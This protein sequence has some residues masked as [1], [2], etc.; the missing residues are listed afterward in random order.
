MR[1]VEVDPVTEEEIMGTLLEIGETTGLLAEE[2]AL[3]VF[4][5]EVAAAG[6]IAWMAEQIWA[7]YGDAI[8][9]FATK[10][11]KAQWNRVR[12][13]VTSSG[14]PRKTPQ[15]NRG[16]EKRKQKRIEFK[17][18]KP[19]RN[20]ASTPER[21][22]EQ[23]VDEAEN[24]PPPDSQTI[25]PQM[26]KWT[27]YPT[28]SMCVD[29]G[30]MEL[31]PKGGRY[32]DK[33]Y[34]DDVVGQW[35]THRQMYQWQ[36]T[37][38]SDAKLFQFLTESEVD[39]TSTTEANGSTSL[40]LDTQ[41]TEQRHQIRTSFTKTANY[42][43]ASFNS[44]IKLNEI[45]EHMP[46]DGG[47][48]TQT[49]IHPVPEGGTY[50]DRWAQTNDAPMILCLKNQ[51]IEMHIK[52]MT[53]AV[54][55]PADYNTLGSETATTPSPLKMTLRVLEALNDILVPVSASGV[56]TNIFNETMNEGFTRSWDI[57]RSDTPYNSDPSV[58]AQSEQNYMV[59]YS[60]NQYLTENWKVVDK[61]EFCLCPGQEGTLKIGLPKKQVLSMQYLLNATKGTIVSG[62][63]G[64]NAIWRMKTPFI[65]KGEQHL[66][67][68]FHGGLGV[69]KVT[70]NATLSSNISPVQVA[71]LWTHSYE[72]AVLH[73]ANKTYTIKTIVDKTKYTDYSADVD[74]N[75]LE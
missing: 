15:K 45:L 69:A 68:E 13:Y 70:D 41:G 27:S 72:Y 16:G 66:F 37:V 52:N 18:S 71:F 29:L 23:K 3:V 59:Y 24:P 5:P 56:N 40:G 6:G 10:M 20:R 1:I 60:D 46:Q 73:S 55:T 14:R 57:S 9:R 65:K 2:A 51:F 12:D 19:N 4:A 62:S 58:L 30:T 8:T 38:N 7:Y 50:E 49:F 53:G 28:T 44:V 31:D 63:V 61:K 25:I 64:T 22:V 43:N 11:T 74:I 75:A 47:G 21:E 54:T 48:T 36:A 39:M 32:G 34:E 35:T 17:K 67:V 26:G 42:R 33:V